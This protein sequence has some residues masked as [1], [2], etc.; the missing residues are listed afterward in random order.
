MS[1]DTDAYVNS[2]LLRVAALIKAE[3]LFSFRFHLLSPWSVTGEMRSFCYFLGRKEGMKY[4]F[5]K[6]QF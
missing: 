4:L 5:S 6:R 3:A 1:I 2:E